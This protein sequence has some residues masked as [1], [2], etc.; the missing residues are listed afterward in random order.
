MPSLKFNNI[1]GSI[2]RRLY[3][4]HCQLCQRCSVFNN[5]VCEQ[6]YPFLP[7]R[8]Q[9]C[10]VCGLPIKTDQHKQYVCGRC[11]QKRPYFDRLFAPLWYRPPISNFIVGF[12]YSNRWEYASLLVELF[13]S[14]LQNNANNMLLVP[15]PSHPKRIRERGFN[16]VHELIRLL[17]QRVDVD[18]HASG[19]KRVIATDTQTGKSKR[20]RQINVKNAFRL[21]Q[22]IQHERIILFDDVVTT[23]A[24]INEV[25]KCLKRQGIKHIEVWAIAR[26]KQFSNAYVNNSK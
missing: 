13:L 1:L 23:C 19:I 15:M 20:E 18:Y 26:T 3:P 6:C 25:S 10:S 5:G 14:R 21:T 7:W 24:T 11:Q 2:G 9:V 16:A 12:K 22:D 8:G 4:W 17:R